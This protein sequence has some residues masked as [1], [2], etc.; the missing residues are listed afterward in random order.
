[1]IRAYR[2]RRRA[3]QN[4]CIHSR[5]RPRATSAAW[6]IG[7]HIHNDVAARNRHGLRHADSAKRNWC[8]GK[9]F[10]PN[11]ERRIDDIEIADEMVGAHDIGK[12]GSAGR[13]D[14]LGRAKDRTHLVLHGCA[15][16]AQPGGGARR[17]DGPLLVSRI[18]RR[19]TQKVARP[20]LCVP[21]IR[22]RM[23]EENRRGKLAT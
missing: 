2:K 23:D 20:H 18:E 17:R 1:M 11:P 6:L 13:T 14:F 16:V 9:F 5:R 4:P 15:E 21:N 19:Q 7:P 22:F 12:R 3:S 10:L 8:A